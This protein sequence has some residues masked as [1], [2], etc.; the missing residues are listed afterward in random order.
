MLHN[1]LP[2]CL[3]PHKHYEAEV[4]SGVIDGTVT[5]EDLDS[6]DYPSR[7]TMD[8]WRLW[9]RKNIANIEG[10]L[11]RVCGKINSPASLLE[12]LRIQTPYWLET[13]LRIIYNTGERLVPAG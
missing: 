9:F 11:R 8:R 1:E 13:A 2:D 12:I 6:E 5:D 4:I 10:I 7:M 3:V